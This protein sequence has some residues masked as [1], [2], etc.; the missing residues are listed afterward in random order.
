MREGATRAISARGLAEEGYGRRPGTLGPQELGTS[1]ADGSRAGVGGLCPD[2]RSITLESAC[3]RPFF[4]FPNFRA[5]ATAGKRH[6]ISRRR[7]RG[8]RPVTALARLVSCRVRVILSSNAD[9]MG[10]APADGCRC[11][12]ISYLHSDGINAIIIKKIYAET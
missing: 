4:P 1:L 10:S 8:D 11:S 9:P 5:C 2:S 7:A 12:T 3:F 6:I